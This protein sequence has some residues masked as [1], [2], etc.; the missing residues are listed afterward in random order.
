MQ[1]K[2]E[3][4]DTITRVV[5][6][7]NT[8]GTNT[9]PGAKGDALTTPKDLKLTPEAIQVSQAV[10]PAMWKQW[11]DAKTM[12]GRAYEQRDALQNSASANAEEK[13]RLTNEYN[14]AINAA[15]AQ[16]LLIANDMERFVG[17]R[18]GKP[19][20]RFEDLQVSQ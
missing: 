17:K 16:L 3:K 7:L 9:D 10:P 12:R 19:S 18:I 6:A 8:G 5:S 14:R 2:A 13:A 15:N 1:P 20:F 4:I 11:R